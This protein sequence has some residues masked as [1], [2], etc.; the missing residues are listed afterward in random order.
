M[1][2]LEIIWP[3]GARNVT[4]RGLPMD[5]TSQSQY[6]GKRCGS[7]SPPGPVYTAWDKECVK[8]SRAPVYANS[9]P[10]PVDES[11]NEIPDRRFEETMVAMGVCPKCKQVKLYMGWN[12]FNFCHGCGWNDLLHSREVIDM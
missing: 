7:K 2:R 12:T 5:F 10:K 6:M 8:Q 9:N 4:A 3:N 11:G 1:A